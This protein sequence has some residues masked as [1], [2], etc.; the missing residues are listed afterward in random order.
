MTGGTIPVKNEALSDDELLTLVRQRDEGALLE[1]YDRYQRPVYRFVMAMSGDPWIAADITQDVFLLMLDQGNSIFRLFSR[2]DPRKGGLEQ[3][4]LGVAR[5]LT[6]R[7]AA[8]ERRWTAIDGD[9]QSPAST[10]DAIESDS[11]LERLRTAIALLPV[12]Y[13]EAVV[14]C[15]LEERS[16]E[17]AAAIAGCSLGTIASRL[18]RARKLLTERMNNWSP[19]RGKNSRGRERLAHILR[20]GLRS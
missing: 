15:Y 5:K 17:Q 16:Y 14:L 20:Q 9:V 13:R 8:K 18:S 11:S 3:Y 2:F 19:E 1:I 12:K 6:R 10:F 7:F 4:L